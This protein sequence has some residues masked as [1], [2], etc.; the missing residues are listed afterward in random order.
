V[1]D[2]RVLAGLTAAALSLPISLA[3]I[4]PASAGGLP[5]PDV[6]TPPDLPVPVVVTYTASASDQ[7]TC[8]GECVEWGY[9]GDID[10]T[11]YSQSAS[12]SV[13]ATVTLKGSDDSDEMEGTGQLNETNASFQS[14]GSYSNGDC[15]GTSSVTVQGGTNP[16]TADADL[17]PGEKDD[18][19]LDW[20]TG[21]GP[22]E[23][24]LVST[25]DSCDG[26]SSYQTTIEDA[27]GDINGV[28]NAGTETDTGWLIDPN[29]SGDAGET[30]A[31]KTVKG[32]APWPDDGQADVGEMDATQTWKIGCPSARTDGERVVCIAEIAVYGLP[33]R[34]WHGGPIPYS[35]GGGHPKIGPSLGTCEG[36]TGPHSKDKRDC[37]DYPEGPTHTVGLDC[38]GFTRWVYDIVYG[39]D[40]LGDGQN[41]SQQ[42]RP[43]IKKTGT[44]AL[45]DLVFFKHK[46]KDPDTGKDVWQ[47]YHVGIYIGDGWIANET[48]T[49]DFT[50]FSRI[51]KR[52][53]YYYRYNG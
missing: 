24:V 4:A 37:E 2:R 30:Y 19:Y 27:M 53:P 47:W 5:R 41:S 11:S 29:W 52:T 10:W 43:G 39:K 20:G 9:P 1:P 21:D 12:A 13:S 38:S 48:Q 16:G 14:S 50:D 7:D 25:F 33:L 3:A 8:T 51:G 49:G 22:L 46:V 15:S 34:D 35:W 17:S 31:T 36:Y 42:D 45:G 44:P 18:I 26:A 32:T 28:N 6:T 23:N 40:V